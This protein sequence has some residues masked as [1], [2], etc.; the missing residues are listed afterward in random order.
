[1]RLYSLDT[2]SMRVRVRDIVGVQEKRRGE[3]LELVQKSWARIQSIESKV[4][5]S[6]FAV[7]DYVLVARVRQPGI[8]PEPMNT[9]TRPCKVFPKTGGHVY[10]LEDIATGRSGRCISRGC[11]RMPM[12]RSKLP[13][14]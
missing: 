12:H 6:D 10:G 4:V 1:M 8:T 14:S 2:D 11:C 5:L 9:W 3:V 7:G 13:L